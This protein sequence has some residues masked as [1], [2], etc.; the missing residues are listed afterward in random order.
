MMGLLGPRAWR[1]WG[2]GH[3]RG[4]ESAL[5]PLP[6]PPASP[7]SVPGGT[8]MELSSAR[9]WLQ[10]QL[11][12]RE[13]GGGPFR[14]VLSAAFCTWPSH[15]RGKETTA[16][17]KYVPRVRPGTGPFSHSATVR[18]QGGPNDADSHF[19]SEKTPREGSGSWQARGK[20]GCQGAGAQGCGGLLSPL[21]GS[22]TGWGRRHP[23]GCG[24]CSGTPGN[25]AAPRRS[26]PLIQNEPGE[27]T[28]M[29]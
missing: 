22:R 13:V 26:P 27:E 23:G 4:P 18:T 9:V 2:S 10:R 7:G 1:P 29:P 11:G 16:S 6:Q 17:S 8:S 19:D 12:A 20:L 15:G 24:Q 14:P 5:A 28:L 21:L 25:P 3:G